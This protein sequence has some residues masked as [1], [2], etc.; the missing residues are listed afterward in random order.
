MR[1]KTKEGKVGAYKE[2]AILAS[3]EIFLWNSSY[4]S[5]G[6]LVFVSFA[7]ERLYL[8]FMIDNTFSQL[9]TVDG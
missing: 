8:E 3:L 9:L 6:R 7:I 2:L 1:L 4:N 5:R